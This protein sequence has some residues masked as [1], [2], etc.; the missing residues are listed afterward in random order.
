MKR[1]ATFVFLMIIAIFHLSAQNWTTHCGNNQRNGLSPQPGPADVSSPLWTVSSSFSATLGMTLYTFGDRFV[2][3]RVDF[4]PYHAI[5]ECR[6]LRTGELLWESPDLGSG[7]IL[8]IMGFN[9][10]AVYAHD[11]NSGYFYALNPLDGSIKWTSENTSYTFAPMDG[12][13]Y[14]CERNIII[15]GELGSAN[16]STVCLDKETGELIWANANLYA[17][18]PNE[19]KAAY[20]NSLYVIIGAINQ[21][22][23]LAAVDIRSGETLY[24][25]DPLPGDADQEGPISIGPDGTIFFRRDGGDL[26]S[27][28]DNGSG[29]VINWTHTPITPGLHKNFVIDFAGNPLFVDNGKLYRLDKDTGTPVDSS[30]I[31]DLDGARFILGDDSVFYINN[32][33][34]KYY[35]LSFDLQTSLWALNVGGNTYAG[36]MLGKDGTMVVCGA[37]TAI[38]AYAYSGMHAPVTDFIADNYHIYVGE[39]VDFSDQSSYNPVTW[40]W[41]FPGGTP[42]NSTEQNPAGI[43]YDTPGI[44]NVKLV[45]TNN[46]GIDTLIKERL[47][48]ARENVGLA[49][50]PDP[51]VQVYPNPADQAVVMR[52]E[53]KSIVEIVNISG[54]PVYHEETSGLYRYIPTENFPSGLYIVKFIINGTNGPAAITTKKLLIQ[55]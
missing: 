54:Q 34:G 49:E 10:D 21:P 35:A 42:A 16:A 8:Y 31:D 37:G 18:T 51:G 36:P 53:E 17:V 27:V 9:E 20:G 14:T 46:L 32:T 5:V 26:F 15:N 43:K 44:Y 29:F 48:Q 30:L 2:N 52:S 22:I 12:V 25:S 40:Y 47:I 3:P 38:K 28:T 6:D 13:I 23:Q 4:S 7:S 11:Y 39:T 55:H 1:I 41:E 45:T 50:N 33:S 24:T 19:T